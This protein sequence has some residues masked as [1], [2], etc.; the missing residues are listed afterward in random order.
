MPD[1]Y[2]PKIPRTQEYSPIWPFE[3]ETDRTVRRKW[4]CPED[5]AIAAY[6]DGVLGKHRR[7]WIEFHLS[8]CLRCRLLVADALKAQRE[9]DEPPVPAQLI[10][11]ARTL[12]AQRR[13][14]RQWLW[15]PAGAL[16]GIALL[17]AIAIIARKPE[18]TIA[19][20]APAPA[21]PQVAVSEPPPAPRLPVPDVVRNGRSRALG[22]S[23][24]FPQPDR[25]MRSNQLRFSWKPIQRSRSYEV[26]IVRTDGDL[27][28]E[29]ETAKSALQV[30]ADI[31]LQDGSYFVWITASLDDGQRIKSPPVRFLVRQP[32]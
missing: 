28:W 23:L 32:H 6:A 15:T 22:P 18:P 13:A 25:V 7:A 2:S 11:M 19:R 31:A 30:P 27:I 5:H 4:W 14:S 8:G 17:I 12:A 20:L 26:R 1:S 3:G 16:A 9:L 21:A 29:G 24:L 10:Q